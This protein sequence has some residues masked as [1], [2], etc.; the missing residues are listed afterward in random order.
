MVNIIAAV[1][2]N[3][4]I[5][6]NG[7]LPWNIKEDMEFFKNTTMGNVVIFGRKTFEGIGSPLPGRV[8]VVISSGK[9]TASGVEVFAD[10]KEA[11]KKYQDR[12]IFICGGEQLYRTAIPLADRMYITRV[13]RTVEG[14]AF[15]PEVDW[16]RYESELLFENEEIE[17]MCFNFNQ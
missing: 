12:E 7:K 16:G 15:F 14:D 9:I 3:N 17:I 2:E 13:K 10:L 5:G 1:S 11:L 8:N 6:L 4:V